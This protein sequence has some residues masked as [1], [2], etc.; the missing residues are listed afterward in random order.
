MESILITGGSG[1]IGREII[2]KI[3]KSKFEVRVLSRSKKNIDGCKV[4]GWDVDQDFIE[5]SALENLD[6]IIHLAGS[7]VSAGR[8]TNSRKKEI[9]DSRIKSIELI[10]SKLKK[11]L[12]TFISAS[13]SSYYGTKTVE[14]IFSEEDEI[15]LAASDFL[16]DVTH[17]WEAAALKVK[18]NR[19]VILRTPVVLSRTGGA[20]EKLIKPIK[21][22]IGSSLGDG[23]QW[24]PWVHVD[25]LTNAY[26]LAI[27]N[28]SMTGAYNVCATEHATN[29]DFTKA[30]ATNLNKNLWAPKVPSFVLKAMFGQMSDIILKGSRVSG[31]KIK[32]T[33]YHY[34]FITLDE[35]L[36]D[37]LS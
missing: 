6:H 11:P 1:I 13:G 22:G 10:N 17:K 2:S 12:K 29:L 24:M 21:G 30:I 32:S 26:L 34:K 33:G 35:A 16:G 3:D 14:Q 36:K 20:L 9:L 4:F 7:N 23:Q 15:Q 19:T 25:D 8:W 5:D 31:K 18:S 27:E 37:L 28:D